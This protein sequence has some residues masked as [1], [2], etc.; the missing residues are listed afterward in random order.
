MDR[1]DSNPGMVER[2]MDETPMEGRPVER[3][4]LGGGSGMDRDHLQRGGSVEREGMQGGG[5]D[6]DSMQGDS[7]E[8]E[9]MQGGGM[10]RD[11]MRGSELDR[12]GM[13]GMEGSGV[14]HRMGS[15]DMLGSSRD[16]S[17]GAMEGVSS[18]DR[19]IMRG[20]ESEP[21]DLS[22][23]SDRLGVGNTNVN[24]TEMRASGRE[25][26]YGFDR[27]ADLEVSRDTME[28]SSRDTSQGT[29]REQRLD[30]DQ[31]GGTTP[32]RDW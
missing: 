4:G 14:R 27:P 9:G 5:S 16:A 18:S 29:D 13:G 32:Q 12:D 8:R 28:G 17:G 22:T 3:E 20:G 6:R 21:S 7:V 19:E 23:P 25:G 11:S 2:E 1:N 15:D 10:D 31:R 26:G 24:D 30:G